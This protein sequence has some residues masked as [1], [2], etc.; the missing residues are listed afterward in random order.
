[1]NKFPRFSAIIFDMD[2][3]VLDTETTYCIA[4]QK[5]AAELGLEFTSTFCLSMSGLHAQDVEK[6]LKDKCGVGFDLMQFFSLSGGYWRDYVSQFGIPVKKGFFSLVEVLKL[7]K[8]PFCLA[9]NSHK[10]NAL[11]CLELAGLNNIFSIIVSRDDVKQGKPAADIF[12]YAAKELTHQ[13]SQC[14]VVEDS[15]TGIQAAINAKAPSIFIPSVFP[16]Q[17]ATKEQANY[18]LNDLDELAQII[19]NIYP[20]PV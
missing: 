8:I 5:A 15:S 17:Q 16:Y 19:L 12:L 6:K 14:L 20:H 4:W 2:G 1:M 13:I 11:E 7:K 10:K 3:L 9:T 18:L